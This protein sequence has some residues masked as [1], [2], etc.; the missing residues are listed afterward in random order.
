MRN[1]LLLPVL[2]SACTSSVG[3]YDGDAVG[4][5]SVPLPPENLMRRHPDFRFTE[6]ATGREYLL[7]LYSDENVRMEIVTVREPG[8]VE[9]SATPAE[10]DYALGV[11][12]ADWKSKGMEDRLR[13]HYEAFENEKRMNATL[14]D[15]KIEDETAAL[16]RLREQRAE[17][18]INLRARRET[19]VHPKEGDVLSTKFHEPSTEFLE[20][21]LAGIEVRIRLGEAR[22]RALEYRRDLRNLTYGRSSAALFSRESLSVDDLLRRMS[23]DALVSRIR[24][25]VEPEYWNHPQSRLEI[26]GSQLVVVHTEPMIRRVKEYLGRMR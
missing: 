13:Y 11:F 3:R 17:I 23:A 21:E 18:E 1:L 25:D 10:R 5:D 6:Y 19:K 20:K 15:L 14:L 9:R 7:R 24:R 12:A 4:P 2:M 22:L 26:E 8:R 16:K